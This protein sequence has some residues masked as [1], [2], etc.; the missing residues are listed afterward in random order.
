M[1]S[2]KRKF[3]GCSS[4]GSPP[5]RILEDVETMKFVVH[6]FKDRTEQRGQYITLPALQAHGY[7][8]EL[9][10]FP[11][12]DSNSSSDAEYVFCFLIYVGDSK[13]KP[14]AKFGIRCKEFRRSYR[15][16]IFENNVGYGLEDCLNREDVLTNFL[17]E[18]GSLVIEVDI[19]IAAE[20]K[21]VWYP[22]NLQREESWTQLY[23]D[24]S[25]TADV[26]FLVKGMEY[27]AHKSILSLRAKTLF[28][29]SKEYDGQEH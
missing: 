27:H 14:A 17:E 8:W 11:R 16:I 7:P 20:S 4:V 5:K 12:G 19:R 6:G 10:C 29:L 3:V 26:V 2:E 15:S 25:E 21:L 18:D 28:E 9:N 22:K 1:N 23:R 24:A 13:Y